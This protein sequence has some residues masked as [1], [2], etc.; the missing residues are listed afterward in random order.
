MVP[1][2]YYASTPVVLSLLF[3]SASTLEFPS[4]S[5]SFVLLLFNLDVSH[6]TTFL[7]RFGRDTLSL[8]GFVRL[9][10]EVTKGLLG[11][12]TV[13]SREVYGVRTN[14]GV[15]EIAA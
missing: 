4:V 10:P 3:R 6:C 9:K 14:D 12:F 11:E 1:G 7:S 8:H 15:L 13:R 5:L 2:W